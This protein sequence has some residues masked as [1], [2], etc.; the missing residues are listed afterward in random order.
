MKRLEAW[1]HRL[2]TLPFGAEVLAVLGGLVYFWQSSTLIHQLP[3]T[4]DEGNYLYKGYLFLSG[5]YWPYQWYGPWTNKMPLAFLIPG[6]AQVLFE[7]GIRTGRYFALFIGL[8]MLVGWWLAARR[9]GGRW[10]A[11]ALVWV[12]AVNPGLVGMYSQA[13]SEG[14]VACMLAWICAL[15]LEEHPASWRVMLGGALSGLIVVT[16]ENLAPV[17]PIVLA[18]VFWQHGRRAGW[19]A[20]LA[21]LVCFGG[22]HAIF[23]PNILQIWAA[24]APAKLTPFLDAWRNQAGGQTI[25]K[26]ETSLVTQFYIFWESFRYHFVALVGALVSWILWP[27]RSRWQSE[28][29]FRAAVFLSVLLVVLTAAHMYAAMGMNYCPFCYSLYLA[30]FCELGLLLLVASVGSW[31]RQLPV[32]RQALAVGVAVGWFAGIAYGAHQDLDDVLLNLSVPRVRG[33]QLQAGSTELWRLLA[34]KFGLEQELLRQIVP[35]VFGLLAGLAFTLLVLAVYRWGLRRRARFSGGYAV[36]VAFLLLG[37]LLSPT[38]LLGNA[39][40][41]DCGGDV[42]AT[43][44]AAAQHLVKL[45]PPGSWIDWRGGL[46]PVPLLYLKDIHIYPAQLNDGYSR[47]VGGDADLLLRRGLWNEVWWQ[48]WLA[49]SDYVLVEDRGYKGDLSKALIASGRVELARTPVIA[50]CYQGSSI[51]IFWRER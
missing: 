33:M 46:S 18:Y 20:S 27:R 12:I 1:L 48:K 39:N 6:S 24:L 50:A 32:W 25:W 42:I 45:I 40:S 51:R 35:P 3:S 14:I 31:Q 34:N 15:L 17:L 4:L 26:P 11:A 23:W 28:F 21:A 37:T 41:V 16:R 19:Y 10:W 30:F 13:L 2:N 47:R 49:E 29:K 8:L 22:V 7:P 38:N 44:E 43:Y 5:Q 36:L 9:L